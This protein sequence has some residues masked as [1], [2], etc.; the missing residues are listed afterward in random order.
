MY[1]STEGK[2]T[3]NNLDTNQERDEFQLRLNGI[4]NNVRPTITVKVNFIKKGSHTIVRID[5]PKG[6]E[7]IYFSHNIPYVRDL[8]SLR[9]A[10]P[11]EVKDAH[12]IYFEQQRAPSV[13]VT[14]DDIEGSEERQ[15]LVRLLFA[16]SDAQIALSDFWSHRANPQLSQLQHDLGS[17][18]D[19][20]L[21]LSSQPIIKR[22]ELDANKLKQIA[23]RLM[24]VSD[25]KFYI[26]QQHWNVFISKCKD[27]LQHIDPIV[28]SIRKRLIVNE[29]SKKQYKNLIQV[30]I[31]ELK[32]D[33]EIAQTPEYRNKLEKLRD[34]FTMYGYR[35]HRMA[36]LHEAEEIDDVRP[37][38]QKLS[39]QLRRLSSVDGWGISPIGF[40]RI[41]HVR[42]PMEDNL[43]IVE[44]IQ[45]DLS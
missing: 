38:L 23:N 30:A 1:I 17:S 25:Y 2:P 44:E 13:T 5:V 22:T 8:S 7:P 42:P 18:A 39:M 36:N 9:P 14:E 45:N 35:F 27:I 40:D 4:R 11:E 37:K 16:L 33:W 32:N 24:E 3:P 31:D 34:S 12:R 41:K 6:N 15:F 28:D 19:E 29:I 10:S 43:K 20:V 21:S 26:G